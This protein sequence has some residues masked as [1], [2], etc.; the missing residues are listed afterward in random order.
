MSI[1]TKAEEYG[2]NYKQ[3]IE[4]SFPILWDVWLDTSTSKYKYKIY[5]GSIWI[6]ILEL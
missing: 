3:P 6:T 5:D 1:L 4:P 2:Y